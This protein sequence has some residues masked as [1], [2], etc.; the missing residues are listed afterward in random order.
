MCIAI[1]FDE[2]NTNEFVLQ[3]LSLNLKVNETIIILY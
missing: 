1:Y 3:I 2:G